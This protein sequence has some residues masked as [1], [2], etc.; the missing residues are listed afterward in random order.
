MLNKEKL[1]QLSGEEL[2]RFYQEKKLEL[3]NKIA[4]NRRGRGPLVRKVDEKQKE[5]ENLKNQISDIL[6]ENP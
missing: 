6:E 1:E 4:K 5:V 3:D 2:E